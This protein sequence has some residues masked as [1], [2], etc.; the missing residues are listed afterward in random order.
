[1]RSASVAAIQEASFHRWLKR[2]LPAGRSG[3]LP[4]GDDAAALPLGGNRTLILTTDALVEGTHFLAQSPPRFVG[5]AAT[6]A[7]LSDAGAKAARPIGVLL[8]ILVPRG[9]PE[10]WARAVAQGAEEMAARFGCHVVGGDTKPSSRRTVVST[11][12]ALG[13]RDT[14]APRGG[15]RPGDFVITTGGTGRGGFAAW[16]LA[17][18]SRPSERILRQLLDIRPRVSEGRALGPL[19]HAMVDTSDGLAE[20]AHLLAEASGV[21][22]TLEWERLP[23]APL[24]RR[25]SVSRS[26]VRRWVFFGGDYE[27]CATLAPGKWPRAR[28]LFHR[29][30]TPLTIVGRVEKGTGAWLSEDRRIIEL[31]YAGW[32]PFG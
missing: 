15:A 30:G 29:I 23:L 12:A 20:S 22:V 6:A 10:S 14:L 31:P 28:R 9:S 1:M 32:Q 8:D 7:S 19:V 21:K 4:L 18:C 25:R 13:R 2:H 16:R 5:R 3:L 27:L 26:R 17:R 24:W 11:V